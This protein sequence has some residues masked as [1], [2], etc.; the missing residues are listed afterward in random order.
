[1]RTLDNAAKAGAHE[2]T[3]ELETEDAQVLVRCADGKAD[4]TAVR[5]ALERFNAAPGALPLPGVPPSSS[6]QGSA[7]SVRHGPRRFGGR[8]VLRDWIPQPARRRSES[9]ADYPE[10]RQSIGW[11]LG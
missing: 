8:R 7:A 9:I 3:V 1:M 6:H 10:N 4:T 5:A 2:F 11:I